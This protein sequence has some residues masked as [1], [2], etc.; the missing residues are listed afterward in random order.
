MEYSW[1]TATNDK[2]FGKFIFT[3]KLSG[4]IIW[5]VREEIMEENLFSKSNG[6]QISLF[7]HCKGKN[8]KWCVCAYTFYIVAAK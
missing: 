6:R 8:D 5:S 2:F 3:L 1:L 4:S 7:K